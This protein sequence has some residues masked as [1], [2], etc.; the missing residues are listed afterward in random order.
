MSISDP[1]TVGSLPM[2]AL[3]RFALDAMRR[4]I[5]EGVIAVGFDDLRPAHVTLFRWP[6]PEGRRPT[7]IADYMGLSK[8]AVN[9]LLR[10]LE[11]RGYL[12][13]RPDPTDDRA[14]IIRLT[15][16]GEQLRQ[17]AVGM[18]G[19]TEMQWAHAIGPERYHQFREMLGQLLGLQD[20]GKPTP[21]VAH[22]RL[23][24]RRPAPR[25]P[26]G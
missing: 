19:Q 4:A 8:Q 13:R 20:G 15:P 21:Q 1:E 2:G 17:A 22:G 25:R 10:D 3:L 5:Y 24:H 12:E 11:D 6:G 9:D 14:R 16:R 18:Q 7:E 23:R 26:A